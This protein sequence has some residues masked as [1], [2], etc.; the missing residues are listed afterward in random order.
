[1]TW[2]ALGISILAMAMALFSRSK[3]ETVARALKASQEHETELVQTLAEILD[4]D[5]T[6]RGQLMLPGKMSTDEA[7]LKLAKAEK[8]ITELLEKWDQERV[9]R[10]DIET[11]V[12]AVNG[13]S[14]VQIRLPGKAVAPNRTPCG[15]LCKHAFHVSKEE[16]YY[17]SAGINMDE[18]PN[19]C[20]MVRP[21][22]LDVNNQCVMFEKES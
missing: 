21:Q 13:D 19:T 18:Y 4:S 1:M 16:E 11:L 2:F 14:L 9:N 5:G 10:K 3:H 8:T 7:T 20:R 17:C 12:E 6:V 15:A 22:F